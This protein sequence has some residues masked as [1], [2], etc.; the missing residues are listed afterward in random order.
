MSHAGRRTLLLAGFARENA[1]VKELV[2]DKL[3]NASGTGCSGGT[4]YGYGLFT[5]GIAPVNGL[6]PL[7]T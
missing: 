5:H 7:G 1:D 6:L 2:I 4:K 3:V